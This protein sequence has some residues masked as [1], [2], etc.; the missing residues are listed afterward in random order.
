MWLGG[1]KKNGVKTWYYD[2]T[3]K[4]KRYR[5]WL[6]P[7][8]TMTKRQAKKAVEKI[9][10]D[11]ILNGPKQKKPKGSKLHK[12]VFENYRTYI[13]IHRPKTYASVKYLFKRFSFFHKDEIRQSDI[14]SYQKKRIQQGVSGATINR[15]LH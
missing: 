9:K 3:L 11:L 14:V 1:V 13:E 7:V 6:G 5:G 4:R 2:F 15:E 10:A 12:Q 8:S